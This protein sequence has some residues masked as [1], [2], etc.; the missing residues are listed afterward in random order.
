MQYYKRIFNKITKKIKQEWK[1]VKK[2]GKKLIKKYPRSYF[3]MYSLALVF[4]S[5]SATHY[6]DTTSKSHSTK[7]VGLENQINQLQQE[8]QQWK[9]KLADQKQHYRLKF[10]QT[11]EQ[12]RKM[13]SEQE[14]LKA[15]AAAY[16]KSSYNLFQ[17]GKLEL[18]LSE[19]EQQITDKHEK[20]LLLKRTIGELKPKCGK[21][22]KNL[23]YCS[24]M[25]VA[26][27]SVEGL[28]K[29]LEY[30][31]GKRDDLHER[32]QGYLLRQVS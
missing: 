28:D 27:Q 23:R 21:V 5:Y 22:I 20:Y 12:I 25:E 7:L 26:Q 3:L 8:N 16:K 19:L 1:R 30:L 6:I 13:K 31:R 4:I 14:A 24:Q 15:K 9:I 11:N 17:A 18:E 32:I 29:Q 10:A 2:I